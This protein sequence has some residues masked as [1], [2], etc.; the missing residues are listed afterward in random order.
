MKIW[1]ITDTHGCHEQLEV[2][3]EAYDIDV[4]IH[5]GDATNYKDYRNE[6]EFYDFVEWYA[7]KVD[8]VNK[9]YVAGNHDM[10][11]FKHEKEARKVFEK[12][13]I[14]YLNKEVLEVEGF[15]IYGEPMVPR[16]ND[17]AFMTD[18]AKMM[19]HW[20]AMPTNVDILATHGGRKGFLDL[21]ENKLRDLETVGC[22]ALGTYLDT[23][24]HQIR[25]VLHGH[26][27]N[28]QGIVNVGTREYNGI[29]YS[30]AAAVEDGYIEKKGI[31]HHGNIIQL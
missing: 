3:F 24:K 17:W 22:R 12:Y 20:E 14:C 26:I 4:V 15:R 10:F 6:K 29:L 7:F 2:P 23:Y 11:I 27:H 5:T 13:G 8:A 16:Y 28:G 18:R 30:N 31:I 1:H 9:V 25:A 21:T 19:K